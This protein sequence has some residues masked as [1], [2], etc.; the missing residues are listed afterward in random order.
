MPPAWKRAN[1]ILIPKPKNWNKNIDVTHLITLIETARKIFTKIMTNRM[2]KICHV[3]N[4]LKGN[5]C[6]VLKGTSTH[7]PVTILSQI[8]KDA[9][10]SADNE[11]WVILQD[12]KKA[13]NSVGWQGLSK[14]L[15]RIKMNSTYVNILKNLHQTR[16]SLIIMA[17]G[18]THAYTIQDGLNQGETHT[19]ILWQIFYDPLLVAMDRVKQSTSYVITRPIRQVFDAAAINTTANN[20]QETTH[21]N[22]L[23][24]VNDIA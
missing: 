6:S 10:F 8:C 15:T 1:I 12:M 14:V 2:E 24:F 20:L 19:L 3:H 11:A 13:Y 18:L 21:I 22:H 7:G 4:I 17:H 9:K 23:A 16:Q 5:N